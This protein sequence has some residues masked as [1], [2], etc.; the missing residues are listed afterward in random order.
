M[1]I[2]STVEEEIHHRPAAAASVRASRS[3]V[4]SF[5]YFSTLKQR[6]KI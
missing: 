3:F 5:V 1:L 4:R 6:R 2:I